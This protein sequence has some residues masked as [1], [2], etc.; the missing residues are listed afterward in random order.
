MAATHLAADRG[1][2]AD[3]LP[4]V[5]AA[6]LRRPGPHLLLGDLNASPAAVA[7]VLGAAGFTLVD[8]PPTFPAVDPTAHIDVVAVR[9]LVP[10]R[11]G[12]PEVWP[13][14]PARPPGGG[15]P[16]FRTG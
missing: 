16:D 7:P 6:L 9:G 8:A 1:G 15:P 12:V 10:G 11:V 4:A 2:V 3:Q 5:V 13:S 14:R